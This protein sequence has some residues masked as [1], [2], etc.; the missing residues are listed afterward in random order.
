MDW[1]VKQCI[2]QEVE[3]LYAILAELDWLFHDLTP[4]RLGHWSYRDVIVCFILRE[5]ATGKAPKRVCTRLL[6][7]WWPSVVIRLLSP[8]SLLKVGVLYTGGSRYIMNFPL[9]LAA[10][11][12][13]T[14]FLKESYCKFTKTG[15]LGVRP[16]QPVLGVL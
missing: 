12:S 15:I 5:T 4:L 9:G 11:I 6:V 7:G 2:F 16:V 3:G 8:K 1:W 14:R 10:T 13:K